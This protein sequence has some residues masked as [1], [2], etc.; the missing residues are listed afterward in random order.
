M[1]SFVGYFGAG[2]LL[3][4][5]DAGGALILGVIDYADPFKTVVRWDDFERTIQTGPGNGAFGILQSQLTPAAGR[6]VGRRFESLDDARRQ[7]M[8]FLNE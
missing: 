3:L 1:S 2:D 5:P 7:F 8:P 4:V 6:F